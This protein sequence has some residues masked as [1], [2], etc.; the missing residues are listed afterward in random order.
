MGRKIARGIVMGGLAGGA[1]GLAVE[2]SPEKM[3]LRKKT[4]EWMNKGKHFVETWEKPIKLTPGPSASVPSVPVPESRSPPKAPTLEPQS[5]LSPPGVKEESAI[6]ADESDVVPTSH[7]EEEPTET[8]VEESLA[9]KAEVESVSTAQSDEPVVAASTPEEVAEMTSMDDSQRLQAEELSRAEALQLQQECLV[10]HLQKELAELKTELHRTKEE[11]NQDMAKAAGATQATLDTLDRLFYERETA[12]G[13]AR[14]GIVV[15]EF[16]YSMSLDKSKTSA[17]ALRVDFES[18]LN[19][20]VRDAFRPDQGTTV[21]Y[22]Q[23]L[24]GKVL[25]YFYSSTAGDALVRM[26]STSPTWENLC[27]I[28]VAKSAISKG[29]FKLAV[30]HLELIESEAARDWVAKAQQAMQLWQGAEAALASMHDD[31]S[32]VL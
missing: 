29:D 12:I 30:M 6:E 18:K 32:K 9:E 3:G 31:L 22:F 20:M 25:A 15:N 1:L 11:H 26:R 10:D 5:E 7:D 24:L 8:T 13:V 28:Q 21:T 17:G 23:L 2:L 4:T 27:A 19:D 14:H 16:L